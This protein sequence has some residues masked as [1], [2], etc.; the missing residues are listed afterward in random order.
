MSDNIKNLFST[1][2]SVVSVMAMVCGLWYLQ[3]S[4]WKY[5]SYYFFAGCVFFIISF[6]IDF[7]RA[8]DDDN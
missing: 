4:G 7:S 5:A 2:F 1:S 3:D 8:D 6:A